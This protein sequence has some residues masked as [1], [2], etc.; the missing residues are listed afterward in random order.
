MQVGIIPENMIND[1]REL[2]IYDQNQ[3]DIKK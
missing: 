2:E 1:Y 3:E